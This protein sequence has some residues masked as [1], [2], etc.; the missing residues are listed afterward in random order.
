MR[1]SKWGNSPAVRLTVGVVE[2]LRLKEGDRVEI[3]ADL[4]HALNISRAPQM[5]K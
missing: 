2:V 4:F 1:I 3:H 5:V